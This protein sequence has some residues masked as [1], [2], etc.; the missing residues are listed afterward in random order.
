MSKP[1]SIGKKVQSRIKASVLRTEGASLDPDRRGPGRSAHWN[2]GTVEAITTSTITAATVAAGVVTYGQ[3]TAQILID[4]PADSTKSIHD[5]A[6]P[7]TVTVYSI[8]TTTGGVASGT[9][10]CLGW[11]N[12][13][14]CL[15]S[16]DCAN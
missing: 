11:R 8:S 1:T 14:W 9:N 4:D 6:Y 12:G 16:V 7:S 10:V 2:P 3:G 13:R 15:I 5:P